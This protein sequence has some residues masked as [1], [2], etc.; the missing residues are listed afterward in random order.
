MAH[1]GHSFAEVLLFLYSGARHQGMSLIQV[2]KGP[3]V[4]RRMVCR[5]NTAAGPRDKLG[6]EREQH[7]LTESP[8]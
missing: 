6:Q 1:P 5:I 8:G 4:W 2:L 3:K 7:L